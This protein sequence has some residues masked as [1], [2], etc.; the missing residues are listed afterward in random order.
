MI[1]SLTIQGSA[2]KGIWFVVDLKTG[3]KI[4][5]CKTVTEAV[6]WAS[7]YIDKKQSKK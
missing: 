3:E 2:L 7:T 5:K 4:A 6:V 1:N